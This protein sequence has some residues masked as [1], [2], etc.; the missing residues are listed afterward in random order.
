MKW[1]T[2][3]NKQSSPRHAGQD[4]LLCSVKSHI[5]KVTDQ[6]DGLQHFNI[7]HFNTISQHYS[8]L[9]AKVTQIVCADKLDFFPL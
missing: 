5:K 3:A 4:C 8:A 9:N 2:V 7:V 6:L 1:M